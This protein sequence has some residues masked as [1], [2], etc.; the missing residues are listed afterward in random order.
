MTEDQLELEAINWLAGRHRLHPHLW[1]R[2]RVRLSSS[3]A[4]ED[5]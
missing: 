1:L 2:Y 5:G 3:P 4:T